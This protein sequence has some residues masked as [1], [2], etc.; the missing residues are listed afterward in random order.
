MF[1][2]NVM[3]DPKKWFHMFNILTPD[4]CKFLATLSK[5]QVKNTGERDHFNQHRV[6][7]TRESKF[8]SRFNSEK[9]RKALSKITGV[10][11][12]NG[13]LRIEYCVDSSGFF[14]KKHY[15][16]PEKLI[17]LQTYLGDGRV[18][19]GTTLYNDDKTYNRLVP[20][21]HNTGW[22]VG[23]NTKLL[24]GVKHNSISGTRHSLI[25]NYVVGDWKDT[26]QLW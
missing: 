24:H 10:E 11:C 21:I 12:Y 19:W 8:F 1:D 26:D 16:I 3:T 18:N 13:K 7:I 4:E 22:L 6:F 20:F 17:T 23:N 15:D 9:T 2:Y 14:L 5:T 25:I